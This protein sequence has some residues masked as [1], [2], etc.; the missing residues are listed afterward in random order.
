M[1]TGR[2]G[3]RLVFAAALVVGLL[4]ESF[5][6]DP[7]QAARRAPAQPAAVGAVAPP[8]PPAATNGMVAFTSNRDG[9]DEI[10]VMG[11]DGSGQVR[12]T[13]NTSADSE[14]AWSPDGTKLA[15]SSDRDGNRE[16][17]VV[18]IDASGAPAGAAINLSQTPG[19]DFSPAW[20][21]DGTKIAFSSD[22]GVATNL[23]SIYLMNADGSN[24]AKLSDNQ[25]Q[26]SDFAPAW[27]PD[28]STVAYGINHHIIGSTFTSALFL[29]GAD[30][31][32]QRFLSP[33]SGA[34]DPAW[35]PD[36]STI[37][38]SAAR[39]GQQSIVTVNPD[40]SG[41]V[42]LTGGAS[43]TLPAWSPDG[44]KVAFTRGTG[45]PTEVVVIGA[46][47][48][49]LTNLTNN[50]GDDREPAWQN[51]P[52]PVAAGACTHTW[53][54]G[55][56]DFTRA[57]FE[58]ASNWDQE[59]AL[60]ATSVVC[61][62][63]GSVT[64]TGLNDAVG[65][66]EVAADA[67]LFLSGS[68]GVTLNSASKLGGVVID[69]T[70]SLVLGA[71]ATVD[72]GTSL[73]AAGTI[74]GSGSLTVDGAVVM[75]AS[76]E[77]GVDVLVASAG[78]V[79]LQRGV[80][81][82]REGRTFTNGGLVTVGPQA[83]ISGRNTNN[84]ETAATT[85]D[86]VFRTTAA[87]TVTF[88][89]SLAEDAVGVGG[90][91]S[92]DNDG[93]VEVL[94]DT[95][96]VAALGSSTGQWQIGVDGQDGVSNARLVF[97]PPSADEFGA[98][99]V[100][101]P[102]GYQITAGSITGPGTAVVRGLGSVVADNRTVD[103]GPA[104]DWSP[105]RTEILGG[106]LLLAGAAR[107]LP[108]TAIGSNG[109]LNVPSGSAVILTGGL[110]EAGVG[111]PVRFGGAGQ[112]DVAV[113]QS[114]TLSAP[115]VV[116]L[117]DSVELLVQG[118]LHVAGPLK[119]EASATLTNVGTVELLAGSSVNVAAAAS[120]LN[121]G[122][123][124][125]VGG[126]ST[127]VLGGASGID[128]T[129]TVRVASGTVDMPSDLVQLSGGRLTGGRI[130]M[131]DGTDWFGFPITTNI[132]D[133]AIRL[134]GSGKPSVD[135]SLGHESLATLTTISADGVLELERSELRLTTVDPADV[136]RLFNRGRLQLDARS[137]LVV[138]DFHQTA[139]GALAVSIGLSGVNVNVFR[140]ERNR[141]ATAAAATSSGPINGTVYA[142]SAAI[143]GTLEVS[144]LAPSQDDV[145][146]AIV[147]DAT[148]GTAGSGDPVSGAFTT[149]TAT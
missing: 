117:R 80:L 58:Q 55:G 89:G 95:V 53:A 62:P 126:A 148:A 132:V 47:G 109:E 129:G 2:R 43:D 121:Q 5:V 149:V 97:S 100:S 19:G 144:P 20:S 77:V 39:N 54:R 52:A 115:Q 125:I 31:S 32:N 57:D 83:T 99:P 12:V 96:L 18:T 91:V 42:D 127:I 44:S 11:P 76:L 140:V 85:P 146:G 26:G 7:V 88:S 92:F 69:S 1:Q 81:T 143:A 40:G 102:A 17:Y 4:A 123:L 106:V 22:R 113:G 56:G 15:F 74:S 71:R 90:E 35:S 67:N 30:G 6:V 145:F 131:A 8:T 73:R 14:P 27:S 33:A 41:G 75:E 124:D 116:E 29:I 82:L 114:V 118:S 135:A 87:G 28:G 120:F 130:E 50:P 86:A 34:V 128:N 68:S 111:G 78:R 138:D 45:G 104:A 63:S 10:F 107:P 48:S 136:A 72:T 49:G 134:E 101:R 37:A 137:S 36:G 13:D 142:D 139:T 84:S 108:A 122:R 110:T 59:T 112:V 25:N 98:G 24:P 119:V 147:V 93:T 103:V 60:T 94:A 65:A 105:S 70:S 21:P 64:F 61:F 133:G 9:D 16:I 51:R 38:F 3:R 66:V 23:R 79:D 141:F 46:D